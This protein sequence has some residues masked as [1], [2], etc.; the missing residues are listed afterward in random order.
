MF[1]YLTLYTGY[2]RNSKRIIFVSIIGL[3]C[4]LALIS[5]SL[6]F[7]DASKT[8]ISN[9]IIQSTN[10][11]NPYDISIN[12]GINYPYVNTTTFGDDISH[13]AN[14]ISNNLN[15]N[16]FSNLELTYTLSNF[17]MP[18]KTSIKVSSHS[19]SNNSVVIVE[20][21]KEV[22]K[23]LLALSGNNSSF[24][25]IN[26][27]IQ[28]AFAL[29]SDLVLPTDPL[30]N[31]YRN[32]N[33][34]N[35]SLTT[36]YLGTGT[37]KQTFQLNV[38]EVSKLVTPYYFSSQLNG[39]TLGNQLSKY[40]ALS[41]II[42]N[43]QPIETYLFV[44]NL[45]RFVSTV[46]LDIHNLPFFQAFG[47]FKIDFGKIDVLSIPSK[48]KDISQF[49]IALQNQIVNSKY[50]K[51]LEIYFPS[52]KVIFQTSSTYD[53][54]STTTNTILFY[55]FFY[56]FPILIVAIFMSTF[57]FGLIFKKQLH[58][59]GIYRT[60]G[61]SRSQILKISLNDLLVIAGISVL[62]SILLGFPIAT[63]VSKTN[64][65]LSFNS[66]RNVNIISAFFD[67]STSIVAI[68]FIVSVIFS[69]LM[70]FVKIIKLT[71]MTIVETEN[72]K[73][74]KDPIWKRYYIDILFFLYG[75]ISYGIL[76]YLLTNPNYAQNINSVVFIFLTLATPSPF[77]L[78]L[79]CILLV[80]RFIPEILNW[81][82]TKLWVL[83]GNIFAFSIKDLVKYSQSSTRAIIL[84]A[85][86][87]S[88][89]LL[90]YT[91]PYSQ[92][93]YEQQ[94]S[95]FENGAEGVIHINNF[96]S[97]LT[98]INGIINNVSKVLHTYFSNSIEAYSPYFTELLYDNGI[99]NEQFIFINASSFMQASIIN[100]I[101]TGLQNSLS[102]DLL[103]LQEIN[104]S[105][106]INRRASEKRG[107]SIN[108]NLYIPIKDLTTQVFPVID[109]FNT[110]PA[111]TRYTWDRN[112]YAIIDMNAFL[113]SPT[114]SFEGTYLS[115][116]SNFGFYLNFKN[117]VNKTAI[118]EKL[119]N[120]L[121]LPVQLSNY[122]P[123]D[124]TISDALVLQYQISQININILII[125]IMIFIILV[126]FSFMQL[127]EKKHELMT[128]RIL[129]SNLLQIIEIFLLELAI[130]IIVGL[131]LGTILGVFLI[132]LLS[133]FMTQGKEIPAYDVVIPWNLVIMTYLLLIIVAVF[134]AFITGYFIIK[135]EISN[136]LMF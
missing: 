93:Q 51:N 18:Q 107:V 22:K 78:G 127:T 106:L 26:S 113:K 16:I 111:T 121:H 114:N 30:I 103:K 12:Y 125:I 33:L 99:S 98:S 83:K 54:I 86:L 130:L 115:K 7:I 53:N 10:T 73:D 14:N 87:L 80:N 46:H 45:T 110:W 69:F 71:T 81:S 19:T 25:L 60:R 88:F 17:Y 24:P 102:K 57:S 129:G 77:I 15:V 104:N 128:M 28:Q 70:N 96:E 72:P 55:I 74:L 42:L 75:F 20:I 76:I 23:E 133:V 37:A 41:R 120:Y 126:L 40:P 1:N 9:D 29:Q 97:N 64:F 11:N 66:S 95:L 79:G 49:Q 108:D 56:S 50:F 4:A 84:I 58:N 63:L 38:T 101:H 39:Y 44:N 105:I 68:L 34:I 6:L 117:G 91:V 2:L 48:V 32:T 123:S 21:N 36:F 90:F 27:K 136:S 13:I 132:N 109:V 89:I 134:D 122:N 65:L 135:T 131:I 94:V 3:T 47:G 35:K 52:I 112:L 67:N 118:S 62:L 5:S 116:V 85:S 31:F 43:N 59:I 61:L 100:Q 119:F 124:W 92:I 82:G 8:N